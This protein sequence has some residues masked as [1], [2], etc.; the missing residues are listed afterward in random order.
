LAFHIRLLLNLACAGD[1][2][3]CRSGSKKSSQISMIDMIMPALPAALQGSIAATLIQ[4][5]A[6]HAS[7]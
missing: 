3:L 4:I 6:L 5:V 2:Q 7:M 1:N